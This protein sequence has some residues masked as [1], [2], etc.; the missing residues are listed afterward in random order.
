MSKGG[1]LMESRLYAAYGSNLHVEHMAHRCPGARIVGTAVLEG[2]RLLYRG[3]GSGFYLTVEPAESRA[4]PVAVWE[5]TAA[6][7]RSLDDY[8]DYPTFYEKME[9]TLP[10]RDLHTGQTEARQVFLY[11]MQEGFPFGLPTADYV[12]ICL[13][14]YRHFGFDA[15]ILREALDYS[16]QRAG[17][18]P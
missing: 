18:R 14:G 8:E 10:V 5:V 4:V 15:G 6:H 9:L 2:N 17:C 16:R 7:E 11:V 3:R 13:A 1:I 12:D